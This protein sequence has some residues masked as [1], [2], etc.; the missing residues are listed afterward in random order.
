MENVSGAV[1][2]YREF[3]YNHIMEKTYMFS[4]T[5]HNQAHRGRDIFL[6][7]IYNNTIFP[8]IE[9]KE[10]KHGDTEARRKHRKY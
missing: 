8:L 1:K 4:P 10:V 7:F 5:I 3:G 6:P 9:I 2:R